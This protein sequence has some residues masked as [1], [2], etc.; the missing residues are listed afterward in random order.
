M[1]GKSNSSS[2]VGPRVC[3]EVLRGSSKFCR[4]S[5]TSATFA[6]ARNTETPS[7]KN[8][9]RA[10]SESWEL[11]QHQPWINYSV[12][13]KFHDTQNVFWMSKY[14][15]FTGWCRYWNFTGWCRIRNVVNLNIKREPNFLPKTNPY[16][17]VK[18]SLQKSSIHILDRFVLLIL[19]PTGPTTQYK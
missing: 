8:A 2:D 9:T 17:L 6:F 10:P 4:M 3:R 7:T 16:H 15:N 13:T 5:F 12:E 19:G 18:S 1:R 11:P 14:W